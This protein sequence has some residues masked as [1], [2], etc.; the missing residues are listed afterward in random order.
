[1]SVQCLCW[2]CGKEI[3]DNEELYEV[4]EELWCESCAFPPKINMKRGYTN[5][6]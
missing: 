2:N 5:N 3:F 6:A 4:N 1:M